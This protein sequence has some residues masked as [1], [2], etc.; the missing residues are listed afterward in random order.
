MS[1]HGNNSA[2][3]IAIL[4]AYF[5]SCIIRLVCLLPQQVHRDRAREIHPMLCYQI[6]NLANNITNMNVYLELRTNTQ[7]HLNNYCIVSLTFRF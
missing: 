2:I 4:E 5:G 1:L 6:L 3:P 7:S